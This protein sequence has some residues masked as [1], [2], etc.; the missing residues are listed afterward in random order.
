MERHVVIED[1]THGGDIQP[2]RRDIAGDENLDRSGAEAV[3]GFG[4]QRLVEI[5]MQ[6]RGV[7]AMLAQ[8]FGD[9]VHIALAITED[10]GVGDLA[11]FL[12]EAAQGFA[13]GPIVGGNVDDF[14]LDVGGGRR[15][16]RDFH[17]HR[18]VQELVGEF[19]NLRRHGRG[20]EQRLA[21]E[22]QLL[23]DL[24]DIR[25]EAHVEH[26]VGF[27]DDEDVDLAQHQLAAAEMI[28]QAARCRD[29]HVH[30]TIQLA[31]LIVEGGAADEQRHRKLVVFAVLL[32]I[33]GHLGGEFA[34]RFQNERTGHARLG[35][36]PREHLDHGQG[37]G[38][39]L[40][41]SGLRDADHIAALEDMRDAL[42]LNGGRCGVTAFGDG[43]QNLRRETEAV[44][45]GGGGSRGRLGGH[46]LG[47]KGLGG[48]CACGF[49]CAG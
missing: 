28:H 31:V 13:L 6:R 49:F 12:D 38:G 30:A 39:G 17:A 14:L 7:E 11:R 45:T 5:A 34:G 9:D 22:G 8:R 21:R 23:A 4:A 43:V 2:A 44:E 46:D 15:G 37:E 32:E 20:V 16:A 35:A 25:D 29:Q 47:R 48:S 26:A 42:R 27:V 36:A 24:F 1:V 18:I 40:A 3:E 41:R 33:L 19:L 10:D